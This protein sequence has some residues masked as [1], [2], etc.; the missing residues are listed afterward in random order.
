MPPAQPVRRE[1]RGGRGA[2][3]IGGRSRIP[4]RNAPMT[5]GVESG[6]SMV[7]LLAEG[8]T[9]TASVATTN[10]EPGDAPKAAREIET[11]ISPGP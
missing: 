10:R 7:S 2:A 8:T 1:L 6:P 3:G 9:R 5:V 4:G 11:S